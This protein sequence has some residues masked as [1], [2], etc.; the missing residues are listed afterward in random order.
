MLRI[1]TPAFIMATL[2]SNLTLA[3]SAPR[4]TVSQGIEWFTTTANLKIHKHVGFII[5]GQY[6][7]AGPF[8][9]MQMQYRGALDI[10]INKQLSFAPLGY[11]FTHNPRYGK[12]PN[13]FV[14][15]EHRFWTQLQYKHHN[16]RLHFTHR[17]RYEI[18]YLQVHSN[19]NGE[20][21][22]QGYDFLANRLRY[23]VQLNIPLNRQKMEAGAVFASVNDEIFYSWGGKA[24]YTKPDQN[25][26]FVGG[27]YQP[28]ERMTITTGFLYQLLIKANGAKQ[29]NNYGVHMTIVY[30]LDLSK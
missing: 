27:G 4:E 22:N 1:I 26:V 3:Q 29:E 14:N 12:Q 8:Q 18:R 7:F 19:N 23:R 28:S 17:A 13:T 20:V 21:V 6:R 2:T 15:N 10:V 25:R 5:D 16:G 30:N 9:P 11:V 24:T